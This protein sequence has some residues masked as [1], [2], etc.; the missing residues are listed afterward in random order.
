ML[1][2]SEI[3]SSFISLLLS[4]NSSFISLILKLLSSLLLLFNLISSLL[5][6]FSLIRFASM[7]LL[8]FP[9]SFNNFISC[10]IS[11]LFSIFSSSFVSSLAIALMSLF[12]PDSS[13]SIFVFDS[14]GI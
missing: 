6:L 8:E 10:S 3:V 5:F 9:C 4:S 14:F 11:L 12:S 7:E 1:L 2:S 13:H